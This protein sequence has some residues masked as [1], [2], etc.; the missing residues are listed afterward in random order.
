MSDLLVQGTD[1]GYAFLGPAVLQRTK[2]FKDG[3]ALGA[4]H[5]TGVIV[6]ETPESPWCHASFFVQGTF[7]TDADGKASR[8]VG[9]CESTDAD[10]D[11]T[12]SI[13]WRAA[14][15]PGR[16]RFVVGTGKWEGISG[17]GELP[18]TVRSRADGHVMPRWEIHWR[19]DRQGGPNAGTEIDP[20]AYANHDQGYS[21]HGPHVTVLTRELSNGLT[22][23]VNNQEGLLISENPQARSPRHYATGFDRGTTLMQGEKRLADVMLLEDTDPDGDIVWLVHTWWYGTGPGQYH[24]IGGTGKWEGISGQGRTLGLMRE[25]MDDFWMLRSEMFWNIEKEG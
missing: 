24:F 5:Q 1:A 6:S 22:L 23:V 4:Y 3:I 14:N 7:V 8:D 2:T 25:R 19:V 10:G 15:G 21:I 17:D 20:A 18:G 16:L 11:L 9:L 13:P 12:W